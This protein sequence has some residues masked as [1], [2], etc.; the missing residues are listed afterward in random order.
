MIVMEPVTTSK[1]F[2]QLQTIVMGLS[3]V[4]LQWWINEAHSLLGL[5]S[6]VNSDLGFSFATSMIIIRQRLGREVVWDA[7]GV[8]QSWRVRGHMLPLAARSSLAVVL[9][10][11]RRRRTFRVWPSFVGFGAG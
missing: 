3:K 7:G 11:W 4:T 10:G 5:H 8:G 6:Q 1:H 9:S 2:L